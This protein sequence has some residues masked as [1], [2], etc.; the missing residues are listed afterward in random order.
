MP[1]LSVS[2]VAET[3]LTARVPDGRSSACW[4]DGGDHGL[5]NVRGDGV[6]DLDRAHHLLILRILDDDGTDLAA[7]GIDERERMCCLVHSYHQAGDSKLGD[8]AAGGHLAGCGPRS[9][10]SQLVLRNLRSWR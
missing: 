5:C 2:A 3:A 10:S 8:L 9:C 4:L 7:S 1:S 6:A